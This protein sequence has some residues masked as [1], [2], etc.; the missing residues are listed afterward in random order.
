[1]PISG[2]TKRGL[3]WSSSS[4]GGEFSPPASGGRDVKIQVLMN[5]CELLGEVKD[6][7][8]YDLKSSYAAAA[9]CEEIADAI[10]GRKESSPR[11]DQEKEAEAERLY[12]PI[13]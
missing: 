13:D 11:S 10:G 5:D 3:W 12:G 4:T 8:D 2:Q 7:E 9:L 1:M 6:L